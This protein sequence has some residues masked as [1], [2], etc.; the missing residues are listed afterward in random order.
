MFKSLVMEVTK[1]LARWIFGWSPIGPGS[2]KEWVALSEDPV[3]RLGEGAITVPNLGIRIYLYYFVLLSPAFLM[4]VFFHDDWGIGVELA[5]IL[6]ISGI[7][8]YL[9]VCGI[10]TRREL[11]MDSHGFHI[12]EGRYDTL[13]PWSCIARGR[14]WEEEGLHL[15]IPVNSDFKDVTS[16]FED[17]E[18]KSIANGGKLHAIR[19]IN[20]NQI[21]LMWIFRIDPHLFREIAVKM[22]LQ[23]APALPPMRSCQ[24]EIRDQIS[25]TSDRLEPVT[26][27][28][29][30]GVLIL[31]NGDLQIPSAALTFPST[32]CSCDKR[33]R[34]V[35]EV[36]IQVRLGWRIPYP[37]GATL[38]IPLCEDCWNQSQG[39]KWL[40]IF[41]VN[42][43]LTYAL[44]AISQES[45]MINPIF[46]LI[47]SIPCMLLTYQVMQV[48]P[49]IWS[50]VRVIFNQTSKEYRIHFSSQT[51]R[52]RMI[53]AIRARD[54]AD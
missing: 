24:M 32:C 1:Q 36:A 54:D 35:K 11:E 33:T 2:Q 29:P 51:I 13:I 40:S 18:E 26:P 17:N 3:A 22:S 21:S 50:V 34:L 12:F 38:S 30:D 37:G 16:T 10:I 48:A 20:I 9:T 15:R 44:V 23:T 42:G 7:L 28:L 52:D 25:R 39:N 5:A 14:D 31:N 4:L 19:I 8:L 46:V 47:C 53:D 43:V 45:L 49:P 41:L 6:G 27:E